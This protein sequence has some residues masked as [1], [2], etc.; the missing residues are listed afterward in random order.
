M[1]IMFGKKPEKKVE[2]SGNKE[3]YDATFQKMFGDS[4]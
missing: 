1:T 4:N 2:T 3:P